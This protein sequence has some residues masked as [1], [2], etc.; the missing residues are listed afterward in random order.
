MGSFFDSILNV[1]EELRY[2]LRWY[3]FDV[4]NH[5]W[6]VSIDSVRNPFQYC[7]FLAINLGPL[8][9]HSSIYFSLVCRTFTHFRP[10][11]ALIL[12]ER[13]HLVSA[14]TSTLKDSVQFASNKALCYLMHIISGEQ[15]M[16]TIFN[17]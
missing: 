11:S 8:A 4:P 14:L 3:M 5:V 12:E 9:L 1:Q 13:G 17:W 16:S 7:F 10:P 6:H 15:R 2:A